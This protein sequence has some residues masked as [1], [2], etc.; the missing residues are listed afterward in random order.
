M[1][2][3]KREERNEIVVLDAGIEVD[4]VEG[5]YGYYCC[6]FGYMFSIWEF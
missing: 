1:K 5:S 3:E 4:G 2:Q 6:S